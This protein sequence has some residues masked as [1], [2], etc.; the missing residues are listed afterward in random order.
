MLVLQ[1]AIGLFTSILKKAG[2]EVD[3]FDATLYATDETVSPAKRVEYLQARKFSYKNDVGIKLKSNPIKAFVSKVDSFKPDLLAISVVEN[4]FKQTLVL[5]DAIKEKNIPHIIGGVFITSAPEKVISYPQIKMICI[6][7]GENTVLQTAERM[8]DG[9]DFYNI[10]NT[11]IKRDD[12]RI[13]KNSIGP[14]VDISKVLP[15]YSLFDNVRFYRPMGG[16]ILKTVPLETYRGC[17]YGC[18]YCNSS[19]WTKFYRENLQTIFLRKKKIDRIIEEIEY[20]IKEYNPGLLYIIDDT[21]LARPEEELREFAKRYQEFR[22]PFWLN[23]RPETI[24]EEKMKLL[25]EMNCYRMSVGLECGNEEFRKNRLNRYIS[26]K[27]LLRRLGILSRS[28]INFSINNI[29][30]FPDETRDLIFDTIE[31]NRKLS[32]YD[33]LTVSIFVPYHGTKLREEAIEKGY[34]DPEIIMTHTTSSSLLSMPQLSSQEIDGLMRTFTMYVGFPKKWWPY[35]KKAEE[36]NPKGNE[37][38]DKLSKIYY[39]VYLSG[40]QFNKPKELPN[41]EKLKERIIS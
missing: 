41:W 15:D 33:A 6:G 20:L 30:G 11:W 35:I 2:F 22:I 14:L 7:E 12:G 32:G 1:V 16:K 38:F 9:A 31:L 40:D 37:M 19:M 28:G 10:Q 3:L 24:T 34:L 27:E 13:I 8:R 26:N 25:S 18:T 39:D 17:P 21:F 29:I 23:T 5:L 4:A 36:F